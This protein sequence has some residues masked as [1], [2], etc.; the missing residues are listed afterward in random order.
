MTITLADLF[1]SMKRHEDAIALYAAVPD[2]SPFKTNAEVQRALNLDAVGRHDEALAVLKQVVAGNVKDQ[3]SI[4]ALGDVLRANEKYA[5]AAE[6]YTRAIDDLGTPDSK[7]WMLY[8]FRGTCFERTKQ[9]DKSEADLK[10][11]L[12]LSPNQPHVLNY[13][14]Y[15]WI[16]QG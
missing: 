6:V 5:E 4:M 15:S 16:D 12:A 1:E 7:D 2:S 9:W 11:A 10:K 3:R 14:G 13:L 8:Y